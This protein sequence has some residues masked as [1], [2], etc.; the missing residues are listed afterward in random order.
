MTFD[1]HWALFLIEPIIQGLQVPTPEIGVRQVIETRGGA[2]NN[3]EPITLG[4]QHRLHTASVYSVR[5][6]T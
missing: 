4:Y 1:P 5:V 2:F 6:L 3:T